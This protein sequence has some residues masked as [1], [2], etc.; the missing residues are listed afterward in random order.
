MYKKI[1]VFIIK[2]VITSVYTSV[3]YKQIDRLKQCQQLPVFLLPLRQQWSHTPSWKT[4]S[5][6]L[7]SFDTFGFD[8]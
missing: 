3:V 6:V 2:K 8:Y 7:A 4:K 5:P 1:I